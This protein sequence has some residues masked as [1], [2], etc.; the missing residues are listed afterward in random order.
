[1]RHHRPHLLAMLVLVVAAVLPAAAQDMA[2]FE[3][4]LTVHKLKNGLTVMIYRRPVAPVFSFFTYVDVGAAQEVP[5][6]TGLAHMFE[7]MAFK[8]TSVIGTKDF[9]AEKS[10]LGKVDA[11]YHAYDAERLKPGGPDAAKL[12]GLKKAFKDA[13]EAADQYIEKN[14][15]SRIV[16]RAGGVGMNASTSSDQTVYFYSLPANKVELWAYLESSRF[17]DPVFREFYKERDVVMEERRLRT[18]STPNGRLFEQFAATAFIA[19]PYKQPVVGYMSDLLSFTREDAEAF[20]RKYYVPANMTIAIVGDV[21]PEEVIPIVESYFGRIPAGPKPEPLRTI[22]PPQT[23]EKSIVL[24]D[25]SQP[26]YLEGYHRPDGLSPDDPIYDVISDVLSTGRTS[27]LYRNL[28]RDKKIAAG[29]VVLNGFPGSKYPT[30]IGVRAVPT[31]GHTNAEV[32]AA[33][34]EQLERL[35]TEPLTDDELKTVKTRA[36]ADLIRSLDSNPG[37]ARQLAVVQTR[38]GDWR[39][40]FRYIEKLE[41]VTKEDVMRVAKATFVAQNRTVGMI[42]NS[43]AAKAGK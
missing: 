39:E 31:P 4:N 30:L 21:R 24:S 17:L 26:A 16:D 10:A 42:E 12:D 40:M 37:L 3:K 14:E 15:F 34:R 32:Q 38:Q 23:A 19:H 27:R 5:G 1:M 29:A 8:G 20:Y 6:I 41:K 11:S 7:H 13:Q 35:K 2:S 18:E 36:K 43:D 33:I 25:P 28:V 22:E 9:A